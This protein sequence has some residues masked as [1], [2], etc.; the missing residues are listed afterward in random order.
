MLTGVD[1]RRERNHCVR[2]KNE[3]LEREMKGGTLAN[4]PG[5]Q[6]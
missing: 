3:G 6:E 5:L 4:I 1:K 2:A